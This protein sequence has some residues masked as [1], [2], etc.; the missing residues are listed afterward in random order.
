MFCG[1]CGSSVP[2]DA[3]VCPNCGEALREPENT[4]VNVTES[5]AENNVQGETAQ[6]EK[7]EFVHF[8]SG[9]TGGAVAADSGMDKS[10]KLISNILKIAAAVVAL[11]LIILVLRAVTA[12]PYKKVVNKFISAMQHEDGE[13][14][15]KLFP[16]EFVD[17]A[18]E[19]LDDDSDKDD[20]VDEMEDAL[21]TVNDSAEEK[22][23]D[24]IKYKV[25]KYKDVEKLDKDEL[26]EL[27]DDLEDIGMERKVKKAYKVEVKVQVKGKDD[28]DSDSITFTIGKVGGKWYM[29][30]SMNSI[31]Y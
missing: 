8:D 6:E 24:K 11:I 22:Y 26:E 19:N 14:M 28:K 10:A 17:K 3:N 25:E 2:D 21:E 16:K 15:L 12:K 9:N 27:N 4:E 1:K 31:L 23:G 5:T 20:L 29:L 30:D 7:D 18:I 13:K